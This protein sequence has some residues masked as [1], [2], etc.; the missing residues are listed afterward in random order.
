MS[1]GIDPREHQIG[2]VGD[3]QSVACGSD[4]SRPLADRDRID[5]L[6]RF[7]IDDR[8]GVRRNE[9]FFGGADRGK[10]NGPQRR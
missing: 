3:P 1:R 10:E 4:L 7:G 2:Q 6:I 9:A 8:H 5:N